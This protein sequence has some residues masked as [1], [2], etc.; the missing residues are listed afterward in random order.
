MQT[1]E[2]IIDFIDSEHSWRR[3]ELSAIR[4]NIATAKSSAKETAL[5]A[6]I[7]LLYAHWEGFVK[8]CAE[9]YLCYVS[10][11]KLKYSELKDNFLAI[12]MKAEINEMIQTKK[13]MYR[14]IS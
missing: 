12:S 1:K 4:S 2:R 9:A 3:K 8:N 10:S 14:N 13:V 6:G 5:R 11:L 7:A